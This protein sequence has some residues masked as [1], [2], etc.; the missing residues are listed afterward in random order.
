MLKIQP[1]NKFVLIKLDIGKLFKFS[2][3]QT[4]RPFENIL[5]VYFKTFD[6]TDG[7]GQFFDRGESYEPA[8]FYHDEEQ[9]KAAE[10]KIQ[11]L[12]EEGIFKTCY[13]ADSSIQNFYPAEDYHQ[14][15]Y[16]KNPAH[17]EQ[18]QRIRKKIIYRN[19]L[20]S[21]ND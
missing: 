7:G 13:N 17:Y 14:D 6:P 8:I 16:K 12:N 11:Q 15:Y 3:T 5:D 10:L 2:S 20:G 18:Y 19:T 21:Q 4:L 9:K 1:M